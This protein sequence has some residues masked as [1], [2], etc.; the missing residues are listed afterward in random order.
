MIPQLFSLNLTISNSSRKILL[1]NVPIMN[2][3]MFL[4]ISERYMKRIHP[5]IQV[6]KYKIRKSLIMIWTYE[7]VIQ[8]SAKY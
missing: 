8:H 2:F 7:N 3:I 6:L 5:T 1:S 4:D